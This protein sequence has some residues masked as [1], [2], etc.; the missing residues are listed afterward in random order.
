M[1]DPTL[2]SLLARPLPR[3]MRCDGCAHWQPEWPDNDPDLDVIG[4]C[5]AQD[6]RYSTSAHDGCVYWQPAPGCGLDHMGV[7]LASPLAQED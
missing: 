1:T 2:I 7:P 4:E 3:G 5:E 6:E